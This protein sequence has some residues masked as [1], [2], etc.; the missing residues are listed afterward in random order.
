LTSARNNAAAAALASYSAPW[1][2]RAREDGPDAD[3]GS[4]C[5]MQLLEIEEEA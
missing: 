2:G 4:R 5:H 1:R 3:E